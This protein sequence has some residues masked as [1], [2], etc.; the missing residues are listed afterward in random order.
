MDANEYIISIS[1]NHEPLQH[2]ETVK[3]LLIKAFKE[4]C[5]SAFEQ[6]EAIGS[7]YQSPFYNGAGRF[8][9]DFPLASVSALLK[10]LELQTGRL[11][12][13]KA[14]GIVPID[15][16]I[17]IFNNTIIHR[18]YDRFPFVRK[19]IDQLREKKCP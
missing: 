11:P 3:A 5:F 14:M 1:S 9:S 19:A 4:V 16:D 6:T 8:T 2:I 12:A 18:D 13:M 15:L 17:I 10:K 7:H